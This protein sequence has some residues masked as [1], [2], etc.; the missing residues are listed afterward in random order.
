MVFKKIQ[1]LESSYR[2]VL[3][4]TNMTGQATAAKRKH[5]HDK[6]GNNRNAK[7]DKETNSNTQGPLGGWE[8]SMLKIKS[9]RWAKQQAQLD[10]DQKFDMLKKYKELRTMG[11]AND[12]IKILFSEM[13]AIIDQV[14]GGQLSDGASV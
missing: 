7:R 14:G 3:D 6:S 5:I 1:R 4:W 10:L 2:V 9:D 12:G 11:Y 13:S 8:A